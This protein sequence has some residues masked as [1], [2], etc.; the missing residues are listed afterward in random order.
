[1]VVSKNN[2]STQLQLEKSAGTDSANEGIYQKMM[3]FKFNT[4]N[5]GGQDPTAK[6]INF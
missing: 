3:N 5:I 2:N 4:P 1:V 6:E